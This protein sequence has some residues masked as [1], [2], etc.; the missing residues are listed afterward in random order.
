[1]TR[2]NALSPGNSVS[3]PKDENGLVQPVDVASIIPTAKQAK[4]NA[5]RDERGWEKKNP[6]SSYRVPSNLCIRAK[7]INAS[8]VN[9]AA[10]FMTTSSSVAAAFIAFSLSHLRAGKLTIEARP[11][12]ERR[13]LSLDWTE[14][15]SG[16]PKE[17]KAARKK[18]KDDLRITER[19]VFLSYRWGADI[20]KQIEAIAKQTGVP[21]GEVVVFLLAYAAKAYHAGNLSLTPKSVVVANKVLPSHRG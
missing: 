17:I 3:L 6:S 15:E 19:S 7:D 8:L 1:M 2:Q 12:P 11:K 13:T 4:E 10:E 21:G 14:T 20:D 5:K 18:K 9:L 16:W